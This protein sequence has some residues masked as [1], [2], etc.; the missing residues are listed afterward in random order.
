VCASYP[1]TTVVFS[2]TPAAGDVVSFS[3]GGATIPNTTRKPSAILRRR[4]SPDLAVPCAYT[5]TYRTSKGISGEPKLDLD[6]I[7]AAF[8]TQIMQAEASLK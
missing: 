6:S 1:C 7:L 4:R 5:R 3:I 2:G 8:A